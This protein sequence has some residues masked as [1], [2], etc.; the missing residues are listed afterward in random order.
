LY[1]EW[2]DHEILVPNAPLVVSE[3]LH[4]EAII[5]HHGNG[6][7]FNAVGSGATIWEAIEHGASVAALIERLMRAYDIDLATA[8]TAVMS[9]AR[10]LAD[11]GLIRIGEDPAA[12]LPAPIAG[13]GFSTPEL[14]VHTDLAD[15]L[16]LD[17]IHDV[18]EGGWPMPPSAAGQGV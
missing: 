3:T 12:P 1:C 11:N 16:M 8:R 5:M 7:Y 17:P 9:F 10:T 6:H 4:G 2:E 14:G 15:M 13:G 18:D